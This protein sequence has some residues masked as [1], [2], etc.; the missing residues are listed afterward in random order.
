MPACHIFA[1]DYL[2]KEISDQGYSDRRVIQREYA[3]AWL[4]VVCVAL[5]WARLHGDAHSETNITVDTT[6]TYGTVG[7][8]SDKESIKGQD[9]SAPAVQGEF[10]SRG[11]QVERNRHGA[12]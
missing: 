6:L 4:A 9:R 8:I 12:G 3:R 2:K 11:V 7:L 10:P 1:K 5:V